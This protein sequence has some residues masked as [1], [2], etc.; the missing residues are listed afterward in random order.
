MPPATRPRRVVA[1]ELRPSQIITTLGPGAVVDQRTTS[2]ITAS[3]DHWEPGDDQRI[4]EPR[5]RAM[6]KVHSLFRPPSKT[7]RGLR[8]IPAFVFPA[9]LVCPRC[10]RLA[11]Y[12]YFYFDGRRF[13]CRNKVG[14]E[15]LRVPP[16]G[17]VAFPARFVVACP[18][19]HLDDLPGGGDVPPGAAPNCGG[20]E[21]SFFGG[22]QSGGDRGFFFY[23]RGWKKKRS[24]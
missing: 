8:G 13:R 16:Q 14:H 20:V 15:R 2:V 3:L 24:M 22:S 1:G 17:P 21:L 6:L 18:A 12:R 23:R 11:H 5:L 10:E 4:D 7:D 19:G 9:F